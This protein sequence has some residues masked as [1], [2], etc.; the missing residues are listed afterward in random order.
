MTGEQLEAA[1][2]A[3]SFKS[4]IVDYICYCGWEGYEIDMP[5][6]ARE[7]PSGVFV[8]RWCPDCGREVE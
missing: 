6:I 3:D 1:A 7:T 8:D 4:T 5:C 2:L